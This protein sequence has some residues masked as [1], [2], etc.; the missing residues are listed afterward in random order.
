[1]LFPDFGHDVETCGTA[2]A[3]EVWQAM[4]VARLTACTLREDVE[5]LS[6][7]PTLLLHTSMV[8][9]AGKIVSFGSE[10]LAKLR[11]LSKRNL[12][13][14]KPAGSDGEDLAKSLWAFCPSQRVS[15][16]I[17]TLSVPA[18]RALSWVP[19]PCVLQSVS[20]RFLH[21][22]GSTMSKS[23]HILSLPLPNCFFRVP[24]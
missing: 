14:K 11:F 5:V 15:R 23:V 17:L 9:R 6:R 3:P 16:R 24:L 20:C 12:S 2:R 19:L 8:R 1:M 4:T 7:I 18:T 21:L 10:R 13:W 22:F